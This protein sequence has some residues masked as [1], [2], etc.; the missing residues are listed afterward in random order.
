RLGTVMR[1]AT[2][3][4]REAEG[5]CNPAAARSADGELYLFPR[6]VAAGNYSRVGRAQVEFEQGLPI[7]VRRLGVALE[8]TEPWERNSQTAGVEDPRIT[9]LDEL[10]V[11]VMC[12]SAYGPLGAK[13]A[14]AV[15]DDLVTWRRLGPVAFCYE[16]A[17]GADLTLCPNKDAAF[18]PQIVRDP[19]G[20]P[21]LALL[22]RP[23][24]RMGAMIP[25]APTILPAGVDDPRESI[26]ISYV[27]LAAAKD[28]LRALTWV[29]GHRLL[30]RPEFG[31]EEVKIGA[32]PPPIRTDAGWLLIHHG[33]REGAGGVKYAAG[34]ML[35]DQDDVSRVIW[36][37]PEPLLRPETGD[38]LS[39]TVD[40][41][42]FPTAIDVTPGGRTIVYYGM[43]DDKIGAAQLDL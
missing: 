16:P 29:R 34:A 32:G 14:V 17:L 24:F 37:S 30:A 2:D 9:R 1:A 39:G 7:G 27:P 10:D 19:D 13:V 20:Q 22:H 31:W 25:G 38:E 5:V 23:F 36:R 18:F 28:D 35:L 8:P 40:H 3:D 12:Y 11:W 42:V 4:P 6:I 43:A 21:A 26:W 41:V 15:S 33:V